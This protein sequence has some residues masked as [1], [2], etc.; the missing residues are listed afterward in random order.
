[1]FIYCKI[2]EIQ[3]FSTLVKD[4]ET[5][6]LSMLEGAIDNPVDADKIKLIK[7]IKQESSVRHYIIRHGLENAELSF[8]IE[9]TLID[10]FTNKNFVDLAN[11]TN[12][13]AGHNAE[14]RGI[15]TVEEMKLY[16]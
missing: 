12:I 2:Q 10:L 7:E 14:A 16:I 5:E 8:E 13:L 9:S 4:K 1:M 6:F 3:K 15:K 11:I